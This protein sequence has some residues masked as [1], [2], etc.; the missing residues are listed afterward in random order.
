MVS[1]KSSFWPKYTQ[2]GAIFQNKIVFYYQT[3][4]PFQICSL[5]DLSYQI[6][7]KKIGGHL[8][9]YRAQF[10]GNLSRFV[11]ARAHVRA[12]MTRKSCAVGMR[13]AIL[14]NY[15]KRPVYMEMGDPR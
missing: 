2:Y 6:P 9:R 5:F 3:F 13:N 12:L 8:F 10:V 14:R 4:L 11:R 1:L 15:L 7:E